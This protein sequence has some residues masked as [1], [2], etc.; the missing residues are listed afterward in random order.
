MRYTVLATF[1]ALIAY[2]WFFIKVALARR[3]FNI[4]APKITGDEAF[5]RIFRVQQNTAEQLVFFLPSLWLC[6]FYTSDPLAGLFGLIW[7]AARVL[8][9]AD[10]YASSGRHGYGAMISWCVA[11]MLLI[12]GTI[13]ALL[14]G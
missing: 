1:M 11:F 14:A 2:N 7:T 8:Y 5:E 4:K 12:G 9:A 6:G 13:G 10:A 3:Q